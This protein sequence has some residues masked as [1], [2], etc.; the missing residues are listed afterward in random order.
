ME[1]PSYKFFKDPK[2]YFKKC[3]RYFYYYMFEEIL[4]IYY[5]DEI[6]FAIFDDLNLDMRID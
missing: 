6:Y 4:P 3:K 1:I 2:I 5:P